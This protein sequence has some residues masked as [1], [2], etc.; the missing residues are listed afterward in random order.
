MTP[1]EKKMR[2]GIA[3]RANDEVKANGGHLPL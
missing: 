3:R 1:E 2:S